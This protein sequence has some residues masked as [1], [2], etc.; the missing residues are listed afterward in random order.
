MSYGVNFDT[1]MRR[2]AIYLDKVLKG[3]R[4]ADL[5]V[6][7]PSVFEMVINMKTARALGLAIPPSILAHAGEVIE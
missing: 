7:Q 2:A 1:P 4:P 6:E 3:I 5:P